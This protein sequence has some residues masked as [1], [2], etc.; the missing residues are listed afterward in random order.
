[1]GL[2]TSPR[3]LDGTVGVRFYGDVSFPG[4]FYEVGMLARYRFKF[5]VNTGPLLSVEPWAGVGVAFMFI[6]KINSNLFLSFPLA[7]GLDL[8][9]GVP[10]FYLVTQADINTINPIGPA[11]HA[12][13][14]GIQYWYTPHY[15]NFKVKAGL[16]YRFY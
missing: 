6:D 10:N 9:L 12:T 1:M 2:P 16:A 11:Y 15:N 14:D 4:P 7:V 5:D 8:Q 13:E 3:G